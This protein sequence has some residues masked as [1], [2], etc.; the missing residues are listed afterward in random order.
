[1]ERTMYPPYRYSNRTLP[2]NTVRTIN[3]T[4]TGRC[5]LF[6]SN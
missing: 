5:V 1:V 4:T 3:L 6:C 2:A